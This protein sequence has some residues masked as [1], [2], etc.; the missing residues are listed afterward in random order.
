LTDVRMMLKDGLFEA[1]FR[2]W[3][4]DIKTL[5]LLSAETEGFVDNLMEQLCLQYG[6]HQQVIDAIKGVP[7]GSL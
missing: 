2:Y 3:V 4:T 1:A 7:K 6:I 5:G